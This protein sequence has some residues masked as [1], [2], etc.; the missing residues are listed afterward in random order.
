MQS[1]GRVLLS[2][3]GG[4]GHGDGGDGKE[5][6]MGRVGAE[7]AGRGNFHF[8]WGALRCLVGFW[9]LG[10][11]LTGGFLVPKAAHRKMG[12]GSLHSR[13]WHRLDRD[14]PRDQQAKGV[15]VL[16][17]PF[18]QPGLAFLASL[19]VGQA[20]LPM[21]SLAQTGLAR[22]S[23]TQVLPKGARIIMLPSTHQP[24]ATLVTVL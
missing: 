18:P 11:I 13:R 10:V 3:G 4:D 6:R 8:G 5:R 16:E 21:V 24:M 23:V 1:N 12:K 9:G 15:W 17:V 19:T 7:R 2:G 14:A 20:W 22:Y